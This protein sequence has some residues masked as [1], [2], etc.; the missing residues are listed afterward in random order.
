MWAKIIFQIRN[1]RSIRSYGS[2]AL[3]FNSNEYAKMYKKYENEKV[4][5]KNNY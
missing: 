5:G 1:S 3:S 2:L 4:T